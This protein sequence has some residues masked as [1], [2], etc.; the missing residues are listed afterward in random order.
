MYD[1]YFGYNVTVNVLLCSD[2]ISTVSPSK[3][4]SHPYSDKHSRFFECTGS[5][6]GVL[7]SEIE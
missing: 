4:S 3:S 6:M 2:L 5:V 1:K 7:E